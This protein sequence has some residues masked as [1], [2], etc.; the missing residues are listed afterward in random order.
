MF[1]WGNALHSEEVCRYSPRSFLMVL[2]SPAIL[3][4]ETYQGL[5]SVLLMI[6]NAALK[7]NGKAFILTADVKNVNGQGYILPRLPERN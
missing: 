2:D 3:T 1:F 5:D 4:Q 6:R 7:I